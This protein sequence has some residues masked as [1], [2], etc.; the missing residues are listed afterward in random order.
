VG[1]AK[2]VTVPLSRCFWAQV[3]TNPKERVFG[4]GNASIFSIP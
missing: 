3:V 1:F 2:M 4:C